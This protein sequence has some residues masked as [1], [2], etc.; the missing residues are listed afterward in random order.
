MSLLRLD[1]LQNR[2]LTTPIH[3]F[4]IK[5]ETVRMMTRTTMMKRARKMRMRLL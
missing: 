2:S 3:H 5:E 4:F 1:H